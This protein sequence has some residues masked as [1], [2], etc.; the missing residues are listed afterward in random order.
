MAYT[1]TR[2][3]ITE[4][5]SRVFTALSAGFGNVIAAMQHS[6]SMQARA[7]LIEQLNNMTD[8]QLAE[9]NITRDQ[10]PAY[11]FRDIYYL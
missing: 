2:S 8:A 6:R 11:V 7:H 4:L 3:P 5:A 9:M 1:M 10:I